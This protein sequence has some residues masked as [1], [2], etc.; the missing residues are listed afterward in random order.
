VRDD[1]GN[2]IPED[3]KRAALLED[4]L[5]SA[6]H[7]DDAMVFGTEVTDADVEQLKAIE[8]LVKAQAIL[9]PV[10]EQAAFGWTDDV[11]AEILTK[12]EHIDPSPEFQV[13]ARHRGHR[14]RRSRDLGQLSRSGAA[15]ENER[16][17]NG[18][19]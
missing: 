14:P 19:D 2:R 4:W 11:A 10:F 13:I 16:R 15:T 5:W 1:N 3:P 9:K 8:P 17:L 6:L 18:R 12:V 7:P